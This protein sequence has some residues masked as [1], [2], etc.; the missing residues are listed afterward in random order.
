MIQIIKIR[1]DKGKIITDI[2]EIQNVIRK[3]LQNLYSIT[4]EKLNEMYVSRDFK[5][6]PSRVQHFKHTHKKQGN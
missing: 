1:N 4:L 5:V 2:K 3:Y 6:K